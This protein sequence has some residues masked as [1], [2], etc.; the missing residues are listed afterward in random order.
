MGAPGSK[1]AEPRIRAG[2][3]PVPA[4]TRPGPPVGPNG[5]DS[6]AESSP[7]AV[8]RAV[9][10]GL[11]QS[12]AWPSRKVTGLAT[13]SRHSARFPCDHLM[14]GSRPR[15]IDLFAWLMLVSDGVCARFVTLSK[16]GPDEAGAAAPSV[17]VAVRVLLCPS[18]QGQTR[19]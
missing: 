15:M 19:V 2:G 11:G 5:D 17:G 13:P 6:P 12:R 9:T 8:A 16:C 3:L 14:S 1:I 7:V 10:S 4:S 18:A